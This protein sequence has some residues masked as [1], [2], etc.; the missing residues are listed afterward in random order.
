[1]FVFRT[2][3]EKD[4][5][6]LADLH[7][8]MWNEFYADFLPK[9]YSLLHYPLETCLEIQRE[10]IQNLQK[11]PHDHHAMIARDAN[12]KLA[13]LCYIGRN[14]PYGYDLD[15]PKIDMELHRL[16]VWPKYRG[17]SL[18]SKLLS[19]AAKWAKENHYK[20]IFAWTFDLNPYIRFYENKQAKI[21][22][23]MPRD[24]EGTSLNLTALGWDDFSANFLKN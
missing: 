6:D 15:I 22:K 9:K 1:M 13:A 21:F 10:L 4:I 18:G 23:Q 19:D 11:S 24:Y 3:Q 5:Q 16:Y 17:Q 20:S 7:F 8:Y 12:G 2:P 14:I